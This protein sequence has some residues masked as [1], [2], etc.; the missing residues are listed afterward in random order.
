MYVAA[1]RSSLSK[2]NADLACTIASTLASANGNAVA[3][4]KKHLAKMA[5]GVA[6]A[7][8]TADQSGGMY[9]QKKADVDTYRTS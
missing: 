9:V 3:A 6:Y 5:N 7:V 4:S 2:T 1:A 8:A